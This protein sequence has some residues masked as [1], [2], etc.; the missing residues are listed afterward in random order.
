MNGRINSAFCILTVFVL[1]LSE[2]PCFP[3]TTGKI[4]GL[5]R[6][7]NSRMPIVGANVSV[8]RP[9]SEPVRQTAAMRFSALRPAY[10]S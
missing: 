8:V 9:T 4:M 2:V 10:M 6:D 1:A 7:Q 3:G 5:I